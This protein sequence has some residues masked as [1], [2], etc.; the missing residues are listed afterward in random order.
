MREI[1]HFI[2]G[3]L[4]FSEKPIKKISN[5]EAKL[6]RVIEISNNFF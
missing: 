2:A 1:R 6:L 5:V 4:K 3:G